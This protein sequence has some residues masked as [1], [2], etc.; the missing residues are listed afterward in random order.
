MAA[1]WD[2]GIQPSLSPSHKPIALLSRWRV[3]APEEQPG[4][5][6]CVRE[7][8]V[9]GGVKGVCKVCEKGCAGLVKGC[10]KKDAQGV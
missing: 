4:E 2:R 10:V 1:P 9:K 5:G 6:T 3:S 8:G 7:R